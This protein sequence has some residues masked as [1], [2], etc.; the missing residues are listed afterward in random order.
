MSK[1]RPDT[2]ASL[3]ALLVL[4][5]PFMAY[6]W[7]VIAKLAPSQTI[8][9][10]PFSALAILLVLL[11]LPYLVLHRLGI[12]WNPPRARLNEPLD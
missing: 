5:L 2:F 3:A 8:T 10:L 4:H 6:A 1:H 7:H 11:L 12:H 9:A